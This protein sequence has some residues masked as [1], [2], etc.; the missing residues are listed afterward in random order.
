MT[1]TVIA[2]RSILKLGTYNL[3]NER[4]THR[5]KTLSHRW[6]VGWLCCAF[7][8]SEETICPSQSD[9]IYPARNIQSTPAHSFNSRISTTH[10]AVGLHTH[11]TYI[12][13]SRHPPTPTAVRSTK[14]HLPPPPHRVTLHDRTLHKQ[15]TLA[16]TPLPQPVSVRL[17]NIAPRPPEPA[18]RDYIRA[19]MLALRDRRR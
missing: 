1:V 2:R 12:P 5:L 9:H 11:I 15:P 8:V 7:C 3:H 13:P 14:H 4:S 17:R 6:Y 16:P 19:G 10:A 18:P